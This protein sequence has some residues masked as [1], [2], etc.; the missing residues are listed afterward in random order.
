MTLR[1]WVTAYLLGLCSPLFWRPR[2]ALFFGR[3]EVATPAA[4]RI[5]TRHGAV[6]CLV[7]RPPASTPASAGELAPV[8]VQIHGGGFYGRL[9]EQDAHIATFI[10]SEVG[11]VVVSIDYDV[12]PQVRYPVAEE[13]CYDVARWVA[14]NGAA[15][16][17]DGSR[18]SIGGESAGGK[19]AINVCQL[20][21]RA[22]TARPCALFAA[23]AVADVKRSDRT[24]PKRHA[25]I[26]R[27]LQRTIGETYFVDAA[28]ADPIAS[29]FYDDDLA[30]AL[31]ATLIMTGADDT[32]A[33]ELDALAERLRAGGVCVEHHRFAATD[34]GFTHGPPLETAREAIGAIGAFLAAA[35]ARAGERA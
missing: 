13:E 2:R 14:E 12:T 22:G 11:A 9:P 23:F 21:H 4:V 28:R 6:R 15:H 1:A 18:V 30:A 5:P 25:K 7:Y 24:S 35:F 17:W 34:H 33:P 3:R 10:A 8:H 31:P 32:L 20:A 16:G 19:L 27:W 29:P 26:A